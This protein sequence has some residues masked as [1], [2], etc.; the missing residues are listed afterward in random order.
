MTKAKV[1]INKSVPDKFVYGHKEGDV[2]EEIPGTYYFAK[3]TDPEDACERLFHILNAP[4]ELLSD[5]ERQVL[6]DYHRSHPSLS[7]G[8]VVEINGKRYACDHVGWKEIS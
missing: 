8:D 2:L 7:M 4:D 6:G 5:A 3:D 1:F